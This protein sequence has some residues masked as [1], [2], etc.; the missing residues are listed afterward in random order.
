MTAMLPDCQAGMRDRNKVGHN[1][2]G[3]VAI[4]RI[5]IIRTLPP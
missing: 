1:N 4:P 3:I 5:M 2:A